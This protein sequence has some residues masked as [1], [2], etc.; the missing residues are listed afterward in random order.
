MFGTGPAVHSVS[1][2]DV[3]TE[4]NR[5]K[6]REPA[7]RIPDHRSPGRRRRD[8]LGAAAGMVVAAALV[9]DLC[10]L[11]PAPTMGAPAPQIA[12]FV[13][14]NATLTATMSLIGAAAAML[15]LPFVASL[16]TFVHGRSETDE[17]RWTMT[18]LAGAVTVS[19]LL[20]AS[21]LRG[22]AA[23]LAQHGADAAVVA[24]TFDVA[25]VAFTFA[26]LPTAALVL[27][28]AR[29][30]AVSNSPAAWLVRV[31]VPIG[32]VGMVAVGAVLFGA[33]SWLGPG[34]TVVAA[35][36]ILLSMWLAAVSTV[37]WRGE[38]AWAGVA[39]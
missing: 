20:V 26:L 38:D 28:N 21:A 29:A 1:M 6:G 35:M 32:L 8:H 16:R 13:H 24:A 9:A 12:D 27:A 25:K 37:M 31:G 4:R 19:V 3:L 14:R 34:E 30:V 7:S 18:I 10:T 17:W 36:G 23:V 11:A 5:V 2:G 22:A 39:T 33:H 15:L